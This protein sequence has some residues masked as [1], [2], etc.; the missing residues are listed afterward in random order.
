MS[1]ILGLIAR[2]FPESLFGSHGC[3]YLRR[4]R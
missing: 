4:L 3:E 2:L 1:A